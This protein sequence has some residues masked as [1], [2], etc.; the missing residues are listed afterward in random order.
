MGGEYLILT[1]SNERI[2]QFLIEHWLRSL[3]ENVRL[4]NVDVVVLDFGLTSSAVRKLSDKGVLVVEAA[5]REGLVNNL[6]LLAARD[7]LVKRSHEYRQI[8][9]C[10]GGDLIFQADISEVFET[11][12]D[13]FRAV[14][15]RIS[16][17]MDLLVKQEDVRVDISEVRRVVTKKPLF[18]VGFMVSP[19][20]VFVRIVDE[21]ES[22][23]LN[24]NRWGLE[25]VL[26]N[27]LVERSGLLC[28]LDAG[29]NFIPVTAVEHYWVEESKFWFRDRQLIPVVHNAGGSRL[30]RPIRDFG[31]G[32]GRNKPRKLMVYLLR[33]FY[34]FISTRRTRKGSR[35]G[36]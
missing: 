19:V 11:C 18:N 24:W 1:A 8:L 22:L 20:D 16:P 23:V 14:R 28:E 2:E 9:M 35:S 32:T 17:N 12:P 7:L 26:L 21:L 30:L 15:E 10:D 33:N 36:V 5:R 34:R 29:Y 25:T 13:R 4:S 3:V 27:Y 31:Y 6:R